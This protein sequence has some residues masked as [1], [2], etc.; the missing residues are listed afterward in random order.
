VTNR[1]GAGLGGVQV[2]AF[3]PDQ[4]FVR[5]GEAVTG[6]DGTYQIVGMPAGTYF[7]RFQPA[8]GSGLRHVWYDGA[9]T[10]ATATP[11]LLPAGGHVAGIDGL[12]LPAP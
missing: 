9:P 8:A 11:V 3:E 2:W 5:T 7:V 6:P 12:L 10:R 4:L 1:S